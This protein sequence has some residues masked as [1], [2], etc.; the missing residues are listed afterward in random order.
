MVKEEI[1]RFDGTHLFPG[2]LSHTVQYDLSPQEAHL[3]SE[4]TDY[5]RGEMN[6][7]ERLVA[8]PP[9]IELALHARDN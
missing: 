6:R 9:L 1:L 5:V 7:V 4:V 2:R 8:D 3:Y